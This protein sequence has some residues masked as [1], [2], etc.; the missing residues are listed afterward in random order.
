MIRVVPQIKIP[1]P[2]GTQISLSLFKEFTIF[3]SE[4]SIDFVLASFFQKFI[5]QRNL[6][7]NGAKNMAVIEDKA[8]KIKTFMM[9]NVSSVIYQIKELFNQSVSLCIS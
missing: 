1:P 8:A 3:A 4:P 9:S 7:K 6:I 2:L 5:L